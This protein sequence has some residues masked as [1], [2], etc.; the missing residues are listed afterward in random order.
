VSQS[1]EITLDYVGS[2][3]NAATVISRLHRGEK[4]LVFVDSRAR[5]EELAATLRDREVETYVS[6]GSLGR[7]GR[8]EV[9]DP[10]QGSYM[11]D[12]CYMGFDFSGAA[13]EDSE[14]SPVEM[15][16]VYELG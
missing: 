6:H 3:A 9:L 7:E 8:L 12:I 16:L 10:P 1:P 14:R 4:R 15:T 2:L 13:D 11:G 5:V